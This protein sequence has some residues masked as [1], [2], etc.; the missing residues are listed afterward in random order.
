VI[1]TVYRSNDVSALKA[2]SQ[3]GR[4]EPAIRLLDYAQKWTAAVDS[5]T[6]E[7]T[8]RGLDGCNAFLDPAVADEEGKRLK[9][10]GRV[11]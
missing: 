9:M 10:P 8:Q 11:G 6:L 5:H 7:E 2:L 4:A 3:N 1:P